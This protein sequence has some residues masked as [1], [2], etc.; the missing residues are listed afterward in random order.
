MR[1]ECEDVEERGEQGPAAHLL[2][3]DE[4]G[5]VTVAGVEEEQTGRDRG[6]RIKPKERY[7]S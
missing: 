1:S 3:R 4:R 2:L 6:R 7:R 5:N